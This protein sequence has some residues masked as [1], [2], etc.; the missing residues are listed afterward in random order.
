MIVRLLY[1]MVLVIAANLPIIMHMTGFWVLIVFGVIG[2]IMCNIRPSL[3]SSSLLSKRLAI[4]NSG[5]E[6]LKLFAITLLL[7]CVL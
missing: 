6:L 2:F 1:V 4:C 7:V 3:K 5:C